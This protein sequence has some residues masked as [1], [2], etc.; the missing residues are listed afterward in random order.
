MDQAIGKYPRKQG[1][2]KRHPLALAIV[3]GL[4]QAMAGGV[5]QAA[6]TDEIVSEQ[7][8]YRFGIPAQPLTSALNRFSDITGWEV[9]VPAVIARGRQSAALAGELSPE[10][11]L[12]R[13]LSGTGLGFRL[14]A[15]DSALLELLPEQTGSALELGATQVQA[16]RVDEWIYQTPRSVSVIT[17]EQLDRNP[18]RHAAD[19]LV[20]TPGVYSAVSAQDPG[21]SVNIRG[22]QDFGRV[23]TMID[24]M[25]QNF[26]ENGHQQRNGQLYV[27]SELISSVVIEKGPRSDVTGATSIAG[28]ANFGTLAYDDIILPGQDQGVR[29]RGMTGLGG[30]GNGVNFIGSAAVAGRFGDNL[31]LLGARSRRSFGDYS[32][33]SRRENFDFLTSGVQDGREGVTQVVDRIKFSNQEQDSELFKGRLTLTPEQSLQF[34]Y[35]GTDLGYN[36]VSDRRVT[37]PVD[38]SARDGEEAWIKYGDASARSQSFGLDY[39]FNPDSPLIDFKAKLYY[40]TT[41]NQRD[42]DAG[43]PIVTDGVDMTETAWRLGFCRQNP[44]PASWEPACEAGLGNE[45]ETRIDTYGFTLDNTARF[46]LG[47]A[48]GFS[49]NHGLEYYQDKGTSKT[50]SDYQGETIASAQNTLN[51]NGK[52]SIASAFG[53]LTFETEQVTL[54]AGLRYDSYWLKGKTQL[55]VTDWAYESRSQYYNRQITQSLETSRRNCTDFSLRESQRINACNNI[56]RFEG[57]LADPTTDSRYSTDFYAGRWSS[58]PG[59]REYQVDEHQDKLL[60]TLSAAYRPTDW[61]EVFAS[62]GKSWRPPA[63][64]ESLMQ[65]SHPGDPFARMYP[66]PYADPETSRSWEL[67][68]NVDHVGL[69]RPDD[70]FQAKVAYYDTRVDNYLITSIVNTLP[71]RTGGLGNT[72][73]VNNQVPMNFRG[74]EFELDY[75]ARRWYT[76]INYTHVIGGDNDICQR[77]YP[78]GS[79]NIREDMPRED[80]SYS[81][82]HNDAIAAGYASYEAYL[83]AQESC[84]GDVFGMNSARNLPM[85]RGSWVVGTRWFNESLELGA[86]LNYSA[87]GGPEDWDYDLWPSYTTWDLFASYRV[88]RNLLLRATVENIRDRSYVSGYSDIFTKSYGPGRTVMGGFELQF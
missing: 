60:P 10:Q 16:D 13:L 11:A 44:I 85:D 61:L 71:G 26:N 33:G 24:G 74:I 22:M 42:N 14:V 68:F 58:N 56:S 78:L 38:G 8:R 35:V 15:A 64:T 46:T 51:P 48:E 34:T 73:F 47:G 59:M 62:W 57:Y 84:A 65:G 83:D 63:L 19:M 23:N 40:V 37:N 50:S 75:D 66:N 79:D 36:N 12:Q 82:F 4:T 1:M 77:I 69:I 54:S 76:G 9:G 28:S 39:S 41:K 20:E 80:G 87:A 21:L 27:D 32:P 53:S 18:P 6:E 29:L 55:P 70:R 67:G 30:H 17:R 86:R 25:R 3:L 5:L 43:R 31:E 2:Y 45:T 52:R 49:F 72:M 88:S 7:Q 81:D